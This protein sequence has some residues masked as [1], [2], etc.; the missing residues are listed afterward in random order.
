MIAGHPLAPLEEGLATALSAS[1]LQP[2]PT[3]ASYIALRLLKELM[4]EQYD[5]DAPPPLQAPPEGEELKAAVQQLQR[6][7]K[8]AVNSAVRRASQVSDTQTSVVERIADYLLLLDGGGGLFVTVDDAGGSGDPWTFEPDNLAAAQS[9]NLNE[10]ARVREQR[11]D[12]GK[13][14][15]AAAIALAPRRKVSY[16][17]IILGRAASSVMPAVVGA[18]QDHAARH[19]AR[20]VNEQF[21]AE[22]IKEGERVSKLAAARERREAEQEAASRLGGLPKGILPSRS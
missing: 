8:E 6:L 21:I 5:I 15:L 13:H 14:L 16:A 22:S 18:F 11:G 19:A 3:R 10:L 1:L 17:R 2:A 20:I 12:S 7:T 4:P 9:A